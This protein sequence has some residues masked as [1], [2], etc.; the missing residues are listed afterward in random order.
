[1]RRDFTIYRD[2]DG[3][4]GSNYIEILPGPFK[5]AWWNAESIFIL[6]EDFLVIGAVI[7]IH[8]PDYDHY[9]SCTVIDTQACVR[10]IRDLEFL[11]EQLAAPVAFASNV[12]QFAAFKLRREVLRFVPDNEEDK[13]ACTKM[14]QNLTIWLRQTMDDYQSISILG[15]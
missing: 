13:S 4:A 2:I 15:M 14:I 9:N 5:Q 3:Q 11:A 7:G 6:E 1:M 10:I 8:V 12:E